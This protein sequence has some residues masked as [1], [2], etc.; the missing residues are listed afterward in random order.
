Q[1]W[2]GRPLGVAFPPWL[3]DP[4]GYYMGGNAMALRPR[5]MLA[6]GEL[7]RRGGAVGDA[8]VISKDWIEASLTP[9][10]Q[11]QWSG[12]GYGYGWFIEEQGAGPIAIARGYGGQI[13]ATAPEAEITV[14]V[15][16][17]PT[18]PARSAGYFGDLMDLLTGPVLNG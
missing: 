9:V 18:R 14:V 16:S 15:T 8:Q 4:Q 5:D 17:D 6:I 1:N 2:L 7:V 11:S 10:T 13:I 12:L 3:R